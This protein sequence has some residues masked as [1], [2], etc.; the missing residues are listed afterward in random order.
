V[1][2]KIRVCP[3]RTGRKEL[4]KIPQVSRALIRD[5]ESVTG[6]EVATRRLMAYGGFYRRQPLDERLRLREDRPLPAHS[7]SGSETM[8]VIAFRAEFARNIV[9]AHSIMAAMRLNIHLNK[10]AIDQSRETLRRSPVGQSKPD[11]NNS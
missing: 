8:D 6:K 4:E 1:T 2:Q 11:S 3:V 9:E 5:D 7:R 10:C